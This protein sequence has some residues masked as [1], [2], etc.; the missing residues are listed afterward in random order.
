MRTP[1][2]AKAKSAFIVHKIRVVDDK[3]E[4]AEKANRNVRNSYSPERNRRIDR[5]YAFI[6]RAMR[7]LE[8]LHRDGDV[9][10]LESFYC[11]TDFA[12]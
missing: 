3:I 1:K 5:M 12:D 6:R 4:K 10:I 2:T 7:D 11:T 8:A 9:E